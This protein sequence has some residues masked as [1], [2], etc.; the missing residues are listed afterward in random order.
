MGEMLAVKPYGG[1]RD[2][3]DTTSPCL[4]DLGVTPKESERAATAAQEK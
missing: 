3:S 2:H 4:A 1:G